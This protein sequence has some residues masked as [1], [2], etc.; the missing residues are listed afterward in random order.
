[1]F[2][3]GFETNKNGEYSSWNQP[4]IL[5]KIYGVVVNLKRR[6]DKNLWELIK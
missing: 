5:A 6:V 3:F 2:C 4:L 1:M